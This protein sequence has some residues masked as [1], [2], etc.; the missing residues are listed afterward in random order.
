MSAFFIW[1]EFS[2]QPIEASI[3]KGMHKKLAAFGGDSQNLF[4]SNQLAI[5]SHQRWVTDED[6]GSDQPLCNQKKTQWF[7]FDGRIDN[8]CHLITELQAT[9]GLNE[10]IEKA[11]S[12]ADLLFEF[13]LCCGQARLP[14]VVG[15]F[16]FALFD[17]ERKE[18]LAA[19][20]AMGG[21][22]LVFLQT[23]QR[24]I[25]ANTEVAFFAYP[26]IGHK[27]NR[28]KVSSWLVNHQE[29]QH[30]ACLQGLFVLNPGEKIQWMNSASGNLHRTTFYRTNPERRVRLNNDQ[31]Y[32]HE[33]RRLL[34]QAV[35]RRLRS[36]GKVGAMLSG[37][38][39][40]VPMTISAA[41]SA[42]KPDLIA[43]S[44][45]FNDSPSMD[46]RHYSQPVC[47]KFGINQQLVECD[48]LW[49]Q[50]D[51]DTHNNPLF[52]FALPYVEFQ[53][54]TFRLAAE[55]GVT[56]MLSGLQG[57]LLYE[58]QNRQALEMIQ[59]FKMTSAFAELRFHKH[60]SNLSWWNALKRY[61]LAPMMPVQDWLEKRKIN[62]PFKSGL[63]NPERAQELKYEPHWLYKESKQALRPLQY[64]IVLDGFAGEDAMLGRHMENK[65]SLERR[66]PFRDRDLCEFMLSIPTEQLAKLGV[67]RPIVKRAYRQEFTDELASRNDK[68][69]FVD[70]L[71]KGIEKDN[72]LSENL[73]SKPLFW[74]EYVKECY[75]EGENTTDVAKKV[76]KWRCAYYNFWYRVWYR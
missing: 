40:S 4:L 68:T 33:F 56:V 21:R 58:T 29:G 76:V 55:Q 59:Q 25:I 16:S 67:S 14:E 8:R 75:F 32:A 66:Y 37:G 69:Q 26:A 54:H 41:L 42:D 50:F 39:D 44:W 74:Q 57:D 36:R 1:L 11:I 9:G 72:K 22:Y 60:N 3:A 13:L 43:Y 5:S 6:I 64:R 23:E 53:Q 38:M 12:D 15:P 48:N 62:K 7:V 65:Y 18:L 27:L 63:L 20:D 52:P 35:A 46:E 70:S 61:L 47:H 28:S 34:D 31:E 17:L 51:Q 30:T 24:L 19:R 45:V 73:N 2:D 71:L 49:P 10:P